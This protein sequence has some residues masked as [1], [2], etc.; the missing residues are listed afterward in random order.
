M[1]RRIIITIVLLLFSVSLIFAQTTGRLAGRVTDTDGTPVAYAN[2]ILVGTDPLMGAQTREDG[3]YILI[4]I[5]VGTY[6]IQAQQIGYR[7]TTVTGQRINV[8]ETATLNIQMVRDAVDIEGLTFVAQREMVVADRT[9][10]TRGITQETIE[11]IAVD[12]IEGIIALQA[13]AVQVGG[14]L[15]IR[16]GRANEVVYQIDGM[17][18]SDPVD[19][20]TAMTIDRNAIADMVVMTG[21]F[22][23]E[24]GN[25][26]SGIVNIVTR[27]G[28]SEYSGSVELISDHII[29]DGSNSD[30]LKVTLGG[31]VFGPFVSDLRNRFTFFFNAA[32]L[33]HDSR[34]RDYYISH[35]NSDLV[36]LVTEF[37]YVDP[38]ADRNQFLGMFDL[39][40]RN[41]N[42]YNANL[43]LTYRLNPRQTMS[44][45]A[46]GDKAELYPYAHSWRYALEHYAKVEEDM[47]QYMFTYDHLFNP[48]MN[49]NVKGSWFRKERFEGPRGIGRDDFFRID[50][51]YEFDEGTYQSDLDG[52]IFIDRT[53][54][55]V[56][57]NPDY[58][59]IDSSYWAFRVF[60][61]ERERAIRGFNPPGSYW[62]RFIDDETTT[63][64]L[65]ADFEYQMSIINNLKT[66]FEITSHEIVKDRLFNP[67]RINRLRFDR[68]LRDNCEV[69]YEIYVNE[70]P[71]DPDSAIEDTIFVYSHYDVHEAL[72]ETSGQTDG[73]KAK[74]W[75]G[76]YYLQNRLQFEGMIANLGLRFDFWHLGND[77]L[78]RQDDGTYITVKWEDLTDEKVKKT[79]VMVSPRVGVSHPISERAVLHFA[80]NYQNQ[81]PQMQYV[82]TTAKPE[83]AILAQETIDVGNPNLE[84]QITITYEV[85]LQR[86]LG[87]D[88]ILDITAY[89][90]NIYNYVSLQER[91]DPNDETITWY[92][93]VSEDYG[94]ARG[95]DI[96]LQKILSN[97]TAGSLSYSFA[98]AQGNHSG[99]TRQDEFRNLREFPLEWDTR[100]AANLNFEFRIG[101]DEEWW[102]PFTDIIFPLDDI[103]MNFI[104]SISSG[105][106]YT[107]MNLEGTQMLDTNSR[108]M[109]FTE[110]A[111]LRLTKNFR[112][113]RKQNVRLF[114]NIN[115]LFNR[116][117]V[118]WVYP[119]T[120]RVDWD[121]Q[122]LSE[123]GSDYVYSEVLHNYT[124]FIKNPSAL[125]SGRTYTLGISYNW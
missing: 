123:S 58:G 87:E 96:T 68:Y 111:N 62:S 5:P 46:R 64:T 107:P 42:T 35:P 19:G 114:A 53:G 39:G 90:K 43:K 109:P 41:F 98:W 118:N 38:Y 32:G 22:S 93:Y 113:G 72:R 92:Q 105:Y 89:Y 25:A 97:F 4:N 121:G 30:E 102:V 6:N 112:F 78:I 119:R 71:T 47:R 99:L 86:Q 60:G 91:V 117:N 79:R 23:A 9:G 10:S 34:F 45:A 100:H 8:N 63:M 20:G 73:Y 54:D 65:R 77:Y 16:G 125:S 21:G 120:G 57:D 48:Q 28:T 33:W 40:N 106:P 84:P 122:D 15:H 67:Q 44:F 70:D 27:D 26:Q 36:N 31:P 49:L 85:G 18:V 115:N 124:E 59:F 2:V 17:S 103:S 66:G 56:I 80:Y 12:S 37:P 14:D 81:L 88:Y 82:F 50:P 116:R 51:D 52:I 74:P 61:T 1:E 7:P 95:V 3:T 75:Q 55:G 24:F 11:N 76:A 83:D 110:N 69:F 13:G 104:Y 94:S 108:R 29:T 101:R